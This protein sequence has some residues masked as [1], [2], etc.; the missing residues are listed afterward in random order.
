MTKC[1]IG[2]MHIKTIVQK[3]KSL[4]VTID[5]HKG[6][7]EGDRVL[8]VPPKC[9]FLFFLLLVH[10]NMP[11]QYIFSLALISFFFFFCWTLVLVSWQASCSSLVM[12][13]DF[14]SQPAS[15]STL[16]LAGLQHMQQCQVD[17]KNPLSLFAICYWSKWMVHERWSLQWGQDSNPQPSGHESS[18]LTTRP[19]LLAQ[20]SPF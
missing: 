18:A 12:K 3:W 10:T 1:K 2:K 7:G 16:P 8:H 14:I 9:F 11:K 15:K 4:F 17:W 5:A 13:L 20:A 19:R 6:E